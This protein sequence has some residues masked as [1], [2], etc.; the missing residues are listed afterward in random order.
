MRA[1]HGSLTAT[2]SAYA[3]P[4]DLL[5]VGGGIHGLPS[6]YEA[7]QPRPRRPRSSSAATSASGTSF[8]HQKTRARRPAL[9]AVAAI[10]RGCARRSASAAPSRASRP[11][12]P[13]LPFVVRDHRTLTR[14]TLALRAA[15]RLDAARA[16]PER[17]RR[18]GPAPAGGRVARARR[19]ATLRSAG[20]PAPSVTGGAQWYD[21]Q[22]VEAD[23]LTLAFAAAAAR[24]A[25]LANYVEAIG[26]HRAGMAGVTRRPRA[27]TG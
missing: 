21:Y 22:M 10:C 17:R 12:G 24:G 18:A 14:P 26:R 3:G 27:S 13:P 6:R 8:N 15:F 1:P 20:A 5:V 2:C 19:A 16:R 23:R 4:F 11:A 9:A 25:E 7:A